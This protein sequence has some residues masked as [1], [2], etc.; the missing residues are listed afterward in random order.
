M[1]SR[2][3]RTKATFVAATA[4]TV[5]LGTTACSG[6]SSPTA[7]GDSDTFTYWSMWKEGEP[8]QKVIAQA[9]ADFEK[10]S[11]VKVKAQWQGRA[12]LQKLV[13]ALNTNAVPDLVDGPYVKAFPALVATDQALGL[14]SVYDQQVDGKKIS[15]IVPQKYRKTIN[16]DL[17]D[18]QPWMLPYQIQSDAIW[19]NG[20][21]FPDMKTNPPKTWDE[22]IADLDKVK[23]AG[24]APIAADGDV[25]GYN[26][27]WLSTLILRDGGC[28]H[29]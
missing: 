15:E 4:L 27:S 3:S 16:I 28:F 9:L 14:Q 1:T 20:A 18:G 6:A 19:F 8:Q 26:A 29:A 2:S 7:K 12:N 24:E 10:E 17:P 22:F 25:A 5:A 21:K 23:A 11:G 13:P